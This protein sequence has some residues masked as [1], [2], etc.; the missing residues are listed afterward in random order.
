MLPLH[1]FR[2]TATFMFK[3][4]LLVLMKSPFLHSKRFQLMVAFLR[5]EGVQI[6]PTA[7]VCASV[8][9]LGPDIVIGDDTFIGNETM[10]T[11]SKG[12]KIIIGKD[13]D[14]S[15]RV[16]IGT[17]THEIDMVGKHSAGRGYGRDVIIEDGVWLGLG[18][19]VMPGV[20]IG[21]KAVIGAG[22]NVTNDILPYCVAVGNP[23]RP[24]KYWDQQKCKFTLSVPIRKV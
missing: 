9:I 11:G 4:I 14:I 8:Q 6:A 22:S 16:T 24:I 2:R 13:V 5:L 7:R 19:I 21:K 15:T 20:R 10:L 18:V 23:C 1:F 17:G 12:T 3:K